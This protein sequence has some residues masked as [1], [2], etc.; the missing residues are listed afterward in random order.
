VAVNWTKLPQHIAAQ[1]ACPASSGLVTGLLG[2]HARCSSA[3]YALLE[4]SCK[5]TAP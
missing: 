1:K 2:M 3:P 5:Q 4:A